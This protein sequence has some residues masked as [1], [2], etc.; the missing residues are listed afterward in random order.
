[1]NAYKAVRDDVDGLIA[2]LKGHPAVDEDFYYWIRALKPEDL[3]PTTQAARFIYLNRTCFNGLHRQNRA[4]QFNVPWG[5]RA[6]PIIC[7]EPTLRACSAFLQN[8]LLN[9]CDFETA[10]SYVLE[11]DACYFDPP[12]HKETATSFTSYTAEGFGPEDQERLRD[13]ALKLARRGVNVALSNSNTKLIRDLY[14]E[15][16]TLTPVAGRR[17]I[18]AN[19]DA[20]C[21]AKDLI[22][23]PKVAPKLSF[24]LGRKNP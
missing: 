10:S 12:Y 14:S 1:M 5:K 9:K 16:F 20:R 21:D 11:G 2:I 13:M 15:H 19:G 6:N 8:K 17:S 22:I 4:G 18:A 3:T 24:S 7:D 23:T